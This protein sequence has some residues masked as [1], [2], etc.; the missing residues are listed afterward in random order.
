MW[1]GLGEVVGKL[2]NNS[3]STQGSSSLRRKVNLHHRVKDLV[4][5]A[6]FR[7]SEGTTKEVVNALSKAS[8]VRNAGM[9]HSDNWK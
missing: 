8:K 7:V 9:N 6:E 1:Q 3:H 4:L 2:R 5:K